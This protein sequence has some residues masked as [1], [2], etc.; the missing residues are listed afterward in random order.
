[1]LQL[2]LLSTAAMLPVQ[3]AVRKVRITDKLDDVVDDEEDEQWR[4]WGTAKPKARPVFDPPPDFAPGMD[5]G[6]YRTEMVKRS[7]GTAMGFVK[8]RLDVRREP[9]EVSRI[10]KK[11]TELLKAGT[12]DVKVMAVDRNTV[13]VTVA[14]GE[15][16]LEV[17][18]FVLSQPEAYEFKLGEHAFRRPGD[19]PLDVVVE[20]LRQERD[21]MSSSSAP[22]K[23]VKEE[24]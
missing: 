16:V 5:L 10:A 13:M 9:E 23:D 4:A 24:L 2:L 14:E 18:D 11:W 12:I 21:G 6:E 22:A 20:R 17:R 15:D 3:A 7:M 19:P 1:M 8:L